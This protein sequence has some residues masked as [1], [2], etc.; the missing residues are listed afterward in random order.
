VIVGELGTPW[1]MKNENRLLG[2]AKGKLHAQDY[3]E[4]AKAMDQLL[5]SCGAHHLINLGMAMAC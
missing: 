2:L 5:N 1:D 3:E 4:P